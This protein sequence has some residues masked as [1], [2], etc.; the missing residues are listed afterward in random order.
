[1][2]QVIAAQ[3]QLIS[4]LRAAL[5]AANAQ[6]NSKEFG[7]DTNSKEHFAARQENSSD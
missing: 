2:A 4:Q 3:H 5:D 7:N 1:M 6:L